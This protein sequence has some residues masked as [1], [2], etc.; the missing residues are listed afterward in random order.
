[1]L[2][3]RDFGNNSIS[4]QIYELAQIIKDNPSVNLDQHK[5]AKN[6]RSRS[7]VDHQIRRLIT[8]IGTESQFNLYDV[9]DLIVKMPDNLIETQ[10]L[11]VAPAELLSLIPLGEGIQLIPNH[12]ENILRK[13]RKEVILLAPFWDTS[14]LMNF[15]RCVPAGNKVELILLLV[16]TGNKIPAIQPI[17]NDIQ[18]ECYFSRTRLYMYIPDSTK[19]FNYPHAKCMAVDKCLGYIGSANFTGPGMRGHFEMGVALSNHDSKILDDILHKLTT[20]SDLFQL[21]WDSKQHI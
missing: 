6:M 2:S 9:I 14:I 10:K 20:S 19:R 15:F 4:N 16:S 13:A 18:A 7:I 8:A 3:S 5:S 1:M 21:M 17:V 12:L 11:L